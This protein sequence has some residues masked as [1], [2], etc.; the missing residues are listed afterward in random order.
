MATTAGPPRLQYEDIG[1]AHNLEYEDI[2]GADNFEDIGGADNLH[3]EDIGGADNIVADPGVYIINQ[4]TD[5][6]EPESTTCNRPPPPVIINESPGV[7]IDQAPGITMDETPD[8]ARAPSN[9]VTDLKSEVAV[10]QQAL[11]IAQDMFR[12]SQAQNAQLKVDITQLE[13]AA[14]GLV[15]DKELLRETIEQLSQANMAQGN[16]LK[17]LHEQRN[18]AVMPPAPPPAA[19]RP[20]QANQSQRRQVD[21]RQQASQLG[22]CMGTNPVKNHGGDTKQWAKLSH[23]ELVDMSQFPGRK[24]VEISEKKP[25]G[26]A[27]KRT[28]NF[29]A[30]CVVCMNGLK[31]KWFRPLQLLGNMKMSTSD[32]SLLVLEWQAGTAL[33][34]NLKKSDSV[35][36]C[37]ESVSR[38]QLI[39]AFRQRVAFV[40]SGN[41]GGS[42]GP[43]RAVRR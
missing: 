33:N 11:R 43:P 26:S 27:Y 38:D 34:Y 36:V 19:Q 5:E 32:K 18:Q 23:D 3:Y 25:G 14:V 2:G 28:L 7:T 21:P 40:T 39:E 35:Q 10:T 37:A 15:K 30:D 17:Q 31:F 6:D 8:V 20:A 29:F 9:P 24:V 12:R 41:G 1:G 16:S 22:G 13:G 42:S 4:D